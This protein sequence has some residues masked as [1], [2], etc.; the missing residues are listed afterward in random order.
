MEPRRSGTLVAVAAALVLPLAGLAL[1]V[2]R[3]ALD[4]RWEHHPAHFWLV[5]GSAALSAVLA[6]ATG[7][8]AARR[9]DARLAHVSLAFLSSAGFLGLHALATPG[10]LLEGSNIG[11]A[12]ATP[13]GVALGSLFALRS[14]RDVAGDGAV[15]EVALARWLRWGLLALMLAWAVVSLAGLP[16]LGGPPAGAERLPL[17]VAV[18]GIVLYVLAAWHYARRWRTRRE[19]VL[20]AVAAAYLLLAQSL[21]AMALARNWQL[22]WWEW[23][24]LLLAAFALVAVGARRSWHEERFAALYL[25]DT[26]AGRREASVLFADLQGFTAFSESQEPEEVT[27]MLNDYLSVAVPAALRHGGDVDRIVGDAVMVT[28]NTRGDQPDHAVRAVRAGLAL[29][30]E[31]S[32]VA[33]RHPG[34]PRFRVGVNTGPAT[35]SVLGTHGGR[36]HTVIGDT[37]NTAARIEAQAPT[38]GVAVGPATLAALPPTARTRPLG[39][40]ELKGKTEPVETHL[41]LGLDREE[42]D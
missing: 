20:L 30:R 41:V 21:V 28:F 39:R 1:L 23:H 5:L 42:P 13:I 12:V 6:Y 36:T 4:L 10:V 8:A 37:V 11:F 31:T 14:T 33:G 16:P 22:S 3:P 17:L 27:A 32:V 29:Q 2:A 40:L 38:G 35:V 34:W 24:V 19:G 7:D 26:S 25:D 9:G 18:P 15:A